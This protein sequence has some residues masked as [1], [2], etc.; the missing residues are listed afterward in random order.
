[1]PLADSPPIVSRGVASVE[2]F[3]AVGDGVTDD[4]GAFVAAISTGISPI[5]LS[6]GKTYVT[7]PITITGKVTL[8]SRFSGKVDGL[9]DYPVIQL[10]AG[11]TDH[12]ITV[13]GG[14]ESRL[15]VEGVLLD[16]NKANQSFASHAIY[17]TS[18]G[19]TYSDSAVLD[20]SIIRNYKGDGIRL[21]QNRNNLWVINRSYILAND[22]HGVYGVSALDSRI[23]QSDV[24][25]NGLSNIRF[26]GVSGAIVENIKVGLCDIYHAGLHNVQIDN[27]TRSVFLLQN[28][29]LRAE[30]HG[31]AVAASSLANPAVDIVGGRFSYNSNSA[32]NTY[33]DVLA[34]CRGVS[35]TGTCHQNN[36][37]TNVIKY[38]IETTANTPAD[39]PVGAYNMTFSSNT[40]A[41]APTNNNNKTHWSGVGRNFYAQSQFLRFAAPVSPTDTILVAHG[42]GGGNSFEILSGG[43]IR[44]GDGAAASDAS[45]ERVAA[46][47]LGS[48]NASFRLNLVTATYQLRSPNGT[49]YHLWVDD[50]GDWRTKADPAP[51]DKNADGTVIGTQS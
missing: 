20:G 21:E 36:G 50:T 39:G 38:I 32:H 15:I 37:A 8:S 33:S 43:R 46:S 40:Y 19:S 1:M 44:W 42:A 12:H 13:A 7:G 3:G 27:Y 35:L 14:T 26:A 23:W 9:H 24:G 6:P 51:T 29:Y 28:D 18:A 47:V 10:R 17:C 11:A 4:T 41:T 25:D 45:M 49:L 34:E 5:G 31:I 22:G 16:G 30:Q 48:L 2:T